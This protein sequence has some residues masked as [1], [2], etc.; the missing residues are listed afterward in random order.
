MPTYQLLSNREGASRRLQSR[1]TWFETWLLT[2]FAYTKWVLVLATVITLVLALAVTASRWREPFPSPRQ[3]RK[4][5]TTSNQLSAAALT[6]QTDDPSS[7]ADIQR[8]VDQTQPG[9][10]DDPELADELN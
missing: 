5:P 2:T 1:Y 10:A 3:R 7:H 6:I 8:A 4:G 9:G